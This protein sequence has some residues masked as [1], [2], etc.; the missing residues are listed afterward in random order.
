MVGSILVAVTMPEGKPFA[1]GLA[2]MLVITLTGLPQP[3]PA[4]HDHGRHQADR[5]S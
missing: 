4:I 5:V 2:T 1:A 3:G